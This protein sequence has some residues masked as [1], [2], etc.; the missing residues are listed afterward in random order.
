MNNNIFSTL[1][2]EQNPQYVDELEAKYK[3]PPILKAFVENILRVQP[4]DLH[5]D[6]WDGA[7]QIVADL[8]L[9]AFGGGHLRISKY[10][11]MY[12]SAQRRCTGGF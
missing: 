10:K 2:L 12:T 9:S 1:S 4:C 11:I 8:N 7:D 6:E 3:L 5:G